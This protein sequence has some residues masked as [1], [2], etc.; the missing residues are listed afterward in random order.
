MRRDLGTPE[1]CIS[2]A[3]EDAELEGHWYG[4]S[5]DRIRGRMYMNGWVWDGRI[6]EAKVAKSLV[7]WTFFF[8]SLFDIPCFFGVSLTR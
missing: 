3:L 1:T 2:K 7:G 8:F 5:E 4:S 6:S